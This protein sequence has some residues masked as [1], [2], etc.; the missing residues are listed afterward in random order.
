M[1]EWRHNGTYRR[2][3][4]QRGG[5]GKGR[6]RQEDRGEDGGW[7]ERTGGDRWEWGT[8]SGEGGVTGMEVSIKWEGRDGKRKD[9]ED[10]SE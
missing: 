1:E 2:Y 9:E 3:K 5:E 8:S 6:R 7:R 4:G 10:G